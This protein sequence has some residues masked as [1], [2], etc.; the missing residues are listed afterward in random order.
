M[1]NHISNELRVRLSPGAKRVL[2]D[3]FK[4]QANKIDPAYH[5]DPEENPDA[6]VGYRLS[7]WNFDRPD[8]ASMTAYQSSKVGDPNGWYNWNHEHWST[9]W[10]AWDVHG[11]ESVTLGAGAQARSLVYRFKTANSAP[12]RALEAMM[13]MFP[14][15]DYT[16]RWED[17]AGPGG[18][19]VG[20]DGFWYVTDSYGSATSHTEATDRRRLRT[21]ECLMTGGDHTPFP[22][23]LSDAE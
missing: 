12:I 15:L 16:L 5:T 20:R 7:F 2:L 23:C 17:E 11:T 6:P 22:D 9:K 1:A 10:D 14:E 19:I 4:I 13:R 8:E 3:M 21:C 18:T